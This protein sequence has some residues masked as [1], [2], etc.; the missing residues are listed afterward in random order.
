MAI[1]GFIQE[2]GLVVLH[3]LHTV[4]ALS[5]NYRLQQTFYVPQVITKIII[6]TLP[7]QTI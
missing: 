7:S 1:L 6:I 3:G 2:K 4:E 5:C